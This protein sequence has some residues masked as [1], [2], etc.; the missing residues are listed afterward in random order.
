MDTT[1]KPLSSAPWRR[2]LVPM[3]PKLQ[4]Q[5]IAAGRIASVKKID[6]YGRW[7][8]TTDV[9]DMFI[10]TINPARNDIVPGAIY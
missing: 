8:Y 4:R 7:I 2:S 6:D 10:S 3:K 1:L 5:L 9:G